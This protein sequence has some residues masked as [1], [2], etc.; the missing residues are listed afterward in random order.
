MKSKDG[1][2]KTNF[3]NYAKNVEAV[4]I[5]PVWITQ[6]DKKGKIKGVTIED[7][8]QLRFSKNLLIDGLIFV[9]VE[10]EII[11]PI[12]KFFETQDF[13]YVEN[14]C[15]VMLDETK[16][17]EV[18]S[19]QTIDVSDA[20]MREDYNFIRKSH[21]TLLMFRRLQKKNTIN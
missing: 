18:E 4:L 9:W 20:Y 15:W 16:K 3:D 8:Q 17:E 19:K 10:K 1:I 7:F 5:N 14:V 2:L 6:K 13:V 21:K 11:W 12:I